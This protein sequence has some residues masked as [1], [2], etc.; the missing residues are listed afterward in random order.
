MKVGTDGVLLGAWAV[1][2][3]PQHILDVGTGTG[4]IALMLAQRF[5]N[6]QIDAIEIEPEAARQATENVSDSPWSNRVVVHNANFLEWAVA[7]DVRYDLI[8]SNPPFFSKAHPT[9][10]AK[11]QLARHD[12][13]LPL[14]AM[15]QHM[16]AMLSANGCV[17]MVFPHERLPELTDYARQAGL[18]TDLLCEVFPTPQKAPKRVLVRF[19]ARELEMRSEQLCIELEQRHRYSEAYKALTRDFYLAF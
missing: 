17:C 13:D 11:R 4:L 12:N 1:H 5:A 8:V 15:L 6:A 18:W 7:D 9:P 14:A 2:K 19:V 10:E 16:R 3:A